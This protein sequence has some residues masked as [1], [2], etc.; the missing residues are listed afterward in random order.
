MRIDSR[1]VATTNASHALSLDV[2]GLGVLLMF[3]VRCSLMERA[4]E[5]AKLLKWHEKLTAKAGLVRLNVAN[6][7]R[8]T[9]SCLTLRLH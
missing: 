5:C 1:R 4:Q 7:F 2:A 8:W 3:G 9:A 6:D